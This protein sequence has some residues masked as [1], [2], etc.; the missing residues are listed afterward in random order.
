MSY[1]YPKEF[2]YLKNNFLHKISFPQLPR[3]LFFCLLV[4]STWHSQSNSQLEKKFLILTKKAFSYLQR[5]FLIL[6]KKNYFLHNQTKRF[7]ILT[8]KK[9]FFVSHWKNQSLSPPK[10]LPGKKNSNEN[11]SQSTSLFI[12]RV[13]FILFTPIL[14][15]FFF[16]LFGK[17]LIFFTSYF[18]SLSLL[19]W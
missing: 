16:Y 15:L 17:T 19:F 4:A 1:T 13:I 2:F 12:L 5:K 18:C 11:I 3:N 8:P 7:L 10:N 14:F 6:I 9:H